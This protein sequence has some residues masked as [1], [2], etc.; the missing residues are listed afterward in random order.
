MSQRSSLL[1][2]MFEPLLS[3]GLFTEADRHPP[4]VLIPNKIRILDLVLT[5]ERQITGV[6]LKEHKNQVL[7]GHTVS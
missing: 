7:E 1:V 5:G 4:G 6:Q 2:G 3:A